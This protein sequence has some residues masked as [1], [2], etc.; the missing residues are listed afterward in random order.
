MTETPG[1]KTR[2]NYLKSNQL[3]EEVGIDAFLVHYNMCSPQGLL[4]KLS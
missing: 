4:L 2:D 3:G 1:A